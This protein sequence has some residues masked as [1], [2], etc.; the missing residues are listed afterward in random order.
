MSLKKPAKLTK[1]AKLIGYA[2]VS[3]QA[4]DLTRQ[5]RALKAERCD[6]I[7]TD[8]ASGKSLAARPALSRILAQLAPGD[9]L[10]VAEWD[11]A[12]RSMWDGLAIVQQ[13]VEAGANIR[14]LDFPSLDLSTPEGQGFLAMFSAM[15]ERERQRILKRT[16][17]GRALAKA[18]GRKMGRKSALS[19]HQQELAR[20][21]RSEGK[22]CRDVAAVFGV[23][24]STIARL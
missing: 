14:V 23:S 16:H 13:V 6:L 1:G 11:R 3:T 7:V 22:S 18:R 9:C 15:A 17:E 2:R 4:Q 24:P 21:M 10:V 19:E 12:T 20:Q 5:I 8:E